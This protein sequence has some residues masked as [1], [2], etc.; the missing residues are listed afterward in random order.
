V[1]IKLAHP[2]FLIPK[3]YGRVDTHPV[4]DEIPDLVLVS[5]SPPLTAVACCVEIVS[6]VEMFLIVFIFSNDLVNDKKMCLFPSAEDMMQ[7]YTP[8]LYEVTP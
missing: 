4:S 5:V 7:I 1:H 8:S 6:I 2:R 3:N